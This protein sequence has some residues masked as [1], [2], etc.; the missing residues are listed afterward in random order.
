[1][2]FG[3]GILYKGASNISDMKPIG[4]TQAVGGGRGG[5]GGGGGD[6][7]GGGGDG[8]FGRGA[9]GFDGGFG[10]GGGQGGGLIAKYAGELGSGIITSFEERVKNGAFGVVLR[11]AP[12][13]GR[14]GGGFGGGDGGIGGAGGGRFGS[15]PPG[16]NGGGG[17]FDDEGGD[18]F[19]GGGGG[20][21]GRAITRGITLLGLGSH[22]ELLKKAKKEGVDVL[23]VF[24]VTVKVNI[25]NGLVTNEAKVVLIEVSKGT[26]LHT[27]TKLNNFK[28]QNNRKAGREDGISKEIEK[29]FAV[30][31]A[32]LTMSNP[33]AA[34]NREVI[35]RRV[36][37]LVSLKTDDMLP[38]LT[39][40]RF[41]HRRNLLDDDGLTK[42][43][44]DI[45]TPEIGEQL[46]NGS[47][48]ERKAIVKRW[49]PVGD[50]G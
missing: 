26:K 18:D 1:V 7:F 28:V 50:D 15:G 8:G 33:P 5:R 34:V 35:A 39:E 17:G 29:L 14:Q 43:F 46:A 11:N 25:K 41:W 48:D 23:A 42:A 19:G 21:A 38:V 22:R 12:Q 6:D 44:S 32:E 49:L 10:G 9:G 24:E 31:D 40:I 2:R 4:T 37:S 30:I 27:T 45:L 36:A 13:A 47:E 16:I 20:A 3:V